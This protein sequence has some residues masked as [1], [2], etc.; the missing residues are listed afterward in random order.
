[1]R[2]VAVTI[3]LLCNLACGAGGVTGNAPL[4]EAECRQLHDKIAEITY[5]DLSPEERDEVA[6]SEADKAAEARECVAEQPWGRDGFECALAAT[7]VADLHTC[8]R[9]SS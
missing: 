2:L 8:I 4:T 7:T 3:V 9:K 1:M 5:R 6:R